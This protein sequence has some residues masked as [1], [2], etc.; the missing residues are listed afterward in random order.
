MP[1]SRKQLPKYCRHKATGQA[2]VRIGGKM[3]YLGKYGSEASR[4]E[5]DRVIAEFL[6]NGR[7]PDY[8]PEEI[9][10]G[11]LILR[12]LDYA[13]KERNYC[14]GT[15]INF[16]VSLG[17]LNDLYGAQPVSSFT[18]AT[19][20]S[21]RRCL[22]EKG[23]CRDTINQH[24]N[25]IRQLFYWG[26]EEEIVPSEIAGSLRMVQPLKE[27]QTSAIDYEDISP[28]PNDI[29]EKTIVHLSRTFHDMARVQRFIS[30]RPQ[31]VINMR[32]CDINRSCEIWKYT[33]FSHKTKKRGKIR[34]LPIG[35]KAQQVLLPYFTR[36]EGD[37]SQFVFV[38]SNGKQCEDWRYIRAIAA[39]CKKAG[40]P[41]WTPNQLRHADG[42]EVRE[43]FGLEY[44]Q[45]VLGHSS[46]KTTEIYAKASFE[47]A[48][49]VAKEIG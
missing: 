45:A 19:L 1:N 4:R 35:P 32:F 31:D 14:D 38:Q 7:Q 33:P 25:R 12:F 5:Y 29:M 23:L 37:M 26:C 20:K 41:V 9:P 11:S 6:A 17:F 22:L 48:A 2:Y 40:V 39:A 34:E 15:K 16:K 8:D 3:R 44:A 27:G 28:V 18:P 43:K 13:E 10:I 47:K 24:I 21:L 36:C 49:K 42:T 46:A 30:G